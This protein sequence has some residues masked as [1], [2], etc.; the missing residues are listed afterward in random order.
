M[1]GPARSSPARP[2]LGR[3]GP[4]L[5]PNRSHASPAQAPHSSS[6]G[7][8]PG[9][10]PSSD[11]PLLKPPPGPVP[12]LACSGNFS[13]IG[14]GWIFVNSATDVCQFPPSVPV[15]KKLYL[16]VWPD[17]GPALVGS[18][19]LARPG[20]APLGPGSSWPASA[21][22]RHSDLAC[23]DLACGRTRRG[24]DPSRDP[25]LELRFWEP[26]PDFFY[27]RSRYTKW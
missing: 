5:Q 4:T 7:S 18:P 8:G 17:P 24:Q 27:H 14:P 26:K 19:G 10:G 1:P 23:R 13:T 22:R 12:R 11:A 15:V 20:A 16:G 2:G 9:W 21:K 6:L 25:G 3:A